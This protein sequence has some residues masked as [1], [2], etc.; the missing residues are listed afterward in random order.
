MHL[1]GPPVAFQVAQH[2]F[3]EPVQLKP[4]SES[5]AV[6]EMLALTEKRAKFE[7]VL[8]AVIDAR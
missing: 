6:A 3:D 2:E 1:A 4:A 7:P 5:A 8:I